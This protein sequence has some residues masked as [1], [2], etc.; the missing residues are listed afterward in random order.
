[1]GQTALLILTSSSGY[2][3]ELIER[4]GI[5]SKLTVFAI[6][7]ALGTSFC[8]VNFIDS[9]P[10]WIG[11]HTTVLLSLTAKRWQKHCAK[12]VGVKNLESVERLGAINVLCNDKTVTST[13]NIMTVQHA[14]Y[15]D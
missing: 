4:Q 1:M 15:Y 9:V 6:V 10:F 8:M 5:D 7:F 13:A 14:C 12:H 2:V 11:I 3:D